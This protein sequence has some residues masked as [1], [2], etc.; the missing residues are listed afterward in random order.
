MSLSAAWQEEE[1]FRSGRQLKGAAGNWAGLLGLKQ[2][3]SHR[4]AVMAS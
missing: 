2:Q 3:V 1:G 4:F